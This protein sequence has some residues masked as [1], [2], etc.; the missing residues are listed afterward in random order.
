M[1][2]GSTPGNDCHQSSTAGSTPVRNPTL[3]R[4]WDYLLLYKS[5]GVHLE[6]QKSITLR[7][8][9]RHTILRGLPRLPRS[10][11]L[12]C[13][14]RVVEVLCHKPGHMLY[15]QRV[16]HYAVFTTVIRLRYDGR[17]TA[18]RRSLIERLK[19]GNVHM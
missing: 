17:S 13:G 12:G 18:Y 4:I 16:N 10:P 6:I 8:I 14:F 15:S 7:S 19:P 2:A 9:R 1:V 11:P 5:S 3:L